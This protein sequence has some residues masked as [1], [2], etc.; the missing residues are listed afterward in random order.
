MDPGWWPWC[1]AAGAAAC[2]VLCWLVQPWRAEFQKGWT[3]IRHYPAAWLIPAMLT[4]LDALAVWVMGDG[5]PVPPWEGSPL[6]A[7]ARAL[8]EGAHGWTFG[9]GAAMV[10][11]FLVIFNA[12]G[13]RRGLLKGAE[14]VTGRAGRWPLVL[15]LTGAVALP[16]DLLLRDR[17]LPVG[18]HV[19][20]SGLAVPLLGWVS[21]AVWG[22][23][24][25]LAETLTR[26]PE[27]IR[28]V[29]WLESAAAHASRLWPWGLAHGI[30]AWLIRWLPE[31]AVSGATLALALPAMAWLFA[32]LHFLHVKLASEVWAGVRQSLA[33][34]LRH[35][36]QAV[37]WLGLAGMLVFSWDLMGRVLAGAVPGP[38]EMGLAAVWTLGQIALTV[39]T[40]GAWVALRLSGHS[41]P[42]RSSRRSRK[43]SPP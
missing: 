13:M 43:A 8:Q 2:A 20:V 19:V 25:L 1:W 37:V 26:A 35:G 32:P 21:A 38:W 27:K 39:M 22:G 34:W 24:V 36:W 6:P 42:A 15:L 9:P 29:R 28:S 12:A 40:L 30:G 41:P 4:G 3:L 31:P 17:G 16:A 14:S 5:L 10:V 33:F 18:W 11:V 7:M 23:L